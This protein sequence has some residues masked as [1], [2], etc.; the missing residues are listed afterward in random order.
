MRL[1]ND[2]MRMVA[3]VPVLPS[4]DLKRS[5]S[6]FRDVLGFEVVFCDENAEDASAGV[7]RDGVDLH[8]FWTDDVGLIQGSG[9]R[10]RVEQIE[11]LQR[12]CSARGLIHPNGELEMKPWG[13]REFTLLEPG[14]IIVTFFEPAGAK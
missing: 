2:P 5:V 14:G 4:T 9:C 12:T 13:F 1:S 7:T 6:F 3:A 8:F 11:T 10:I